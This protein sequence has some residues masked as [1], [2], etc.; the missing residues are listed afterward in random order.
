MA[1]NSLLLGGGL[2]FSNIS[3]SETLPPEV[4]KSMR[5]GF[6]LGAGLEFGITPMFS[7]LPGAIAIRPG[8]SISL[9]NF[10]DSKPDPEFAEDPEDPDVKVKHTNLKLTV[11]YKISL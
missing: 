3:F 4:K 11:A 6:N 10:D 2:D 8:Y 7:I 5:T 9:T 1:G